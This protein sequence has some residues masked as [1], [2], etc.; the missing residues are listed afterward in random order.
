[1]FGQGVANNHNSKSSPGSGDPNEIFLAY[2]QDENSIQLTCYG[3]SKTII[4]GR[5]SNINTGHSTVFIENMTFFN[6][7]SVYHNFTNL[8]PG[9]YVVRVVYKD[10][11][12]NMSEETNINNMNRYANI[13]FVK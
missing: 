7:Q 11:D 10:E 6:H 9:V 8:V 2:H 3:G 12:S 1:M 13:T 5:I 4:L